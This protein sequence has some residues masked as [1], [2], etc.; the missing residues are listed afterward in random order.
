MSDFIPDSA[1][2]PDVS[3]VSSAS[4]FIP[5]SQFKSDQPIDEQAKANA[6]EQQEQQLQSQ[7]GTGTQQAIAGAEAVGKGLAG[8]LAT[9]AEVALGVSPEDI[10]GREEANPIT[11]VAG[12]VAGLVSPIGQGAL[13]AKIGSKAALP[14]VSKGV[15][16][17][18]SR[19][20]VKLAAENALF[21]GGDEVSKMILQD[22]N[23]SVQTAVTNVGLAAILGGAVGGAF[24]TV[25]PLWHATVGNKADQFIADFKG[26]MQE[27]LD[28]PEPLQ[29]FTNEL[30]EYHKNITGMADEVYG[31]KGLKTQEIQKLMPEMSPK[32]SQQ[33]EDISQKA[34]N[35]MQD[36]HKKAVPERYMMKLNNDINKFQEVA[37]NPE[38]SPT[39]L[40]DAAQEFKQTVQGYSKGNFGPFAIPSYHEAYD[41]LN[42]TK[43]LGRDLRT[44]LE[45]PGVWGKAG[46]RQ[47]AINKAFSEYKPALDD[48]NKKFTSEV[49]GER[50]I[51]PGKT[52]T[53]INQLGKPNAEL[54]QQM[55]ENFINA[56]EKY[57][58]VVSDTHS[59]LGL[60]NPMPASSLNAVQATLKDIPAG[61]KLADVFIKKVA[62]KLGGTL[63]GGTLG[64]LT[65]IPFGEI[66]GAYFGEKFLGSIL[67]S[68]VKPILSGISSGE[69]LHAAN[70]YGSSVVRGSTLISN[71]TKNI[72]KSGSKVLPENKMPDKDQRE[73]LNTALLD[74]QKDPAKLVDISGK[75]GHYMP[76]Q[77]ASLGSMS[78]NIV[79]FLNS[80]RPNPVKKAPLDPEIQPSQ[81]VKA[82]FDRAL[83]IAQQP[84]IVLQSIK[85]N[86]LTSHDV[87]AIQKM[88]PSLYNNLKQHLMDEMIRFTSKGDSIPY[89]TRLSMSLFMAQPLDSTMSSTS[90]LLAQPAPEQP[91]QQSQQAPKKGAPSRLKGEGAKLAT[92]GDQNA[93]AISNGARKA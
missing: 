3:E 21:Q 17:G 54:K 72:L 4:G 78:Q 34:E 56:S 52:N 41:F 75:V 29:N 32:I 30:S 15:L 70:E 61:S 74:L 43:N 10:R 77:A 42:V 55:L 9:G 66:G 18:I 7:Y 19:N 80:I 60:D 47:Q 93:E 58:K 13:L 81:A 53:Y 57:K 85:D 31:P 45:D 11:H 67:P 87:M 63:I 82:Q 1:F 2:K 69:A 37:T 49:N 28:N 23:Q 14:I 22:P 36:L 86:T 91:Q 16:A 73:K 90:I 25:S 40:F 83:D 44:S 68:I 8:P 20:A 64:R 39:Q 62:D 92:T 76:E 89:N 84:L 46:E 38:A 88:Y 51:D 59:N 71:A 50:V 48:F 35:A 79:L 5:D 27:H 6:A 24:G 26:R 12:E 65:G 33:M